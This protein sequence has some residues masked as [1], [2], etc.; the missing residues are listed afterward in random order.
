MTEM[1]EELLKNNEELIGQNRKLLDE[2]ISLMKESEL[3]IRQNF[4]L[5]AMEKSTNEV[6]QCCNDPQKLS[7]LLI[8]VMEQ[9]R[10]M[11]QGN[12]TLMKEIELYKAQQAQSSKQNIELAG[13]CDALMKESETNMQHNIKLMT[14]TKQMVESNMKLIAELE[15]MKTEKK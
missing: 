5:R 4:T 13:H 2:N 14:V 6:I 10:S 15:R 11:M 1:V 12:M 3:L 7:G 9:N 8:A